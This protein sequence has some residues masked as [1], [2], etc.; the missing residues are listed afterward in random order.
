MPTQSPFWVSLTEAK[1]HVGLALWVTDAFK[2]AKVVLLCFGFPRLYIPVYSFKIFHFRFAKL[3]L[4]Y[5]LWFFTWSSESLSEIMWRISLTNQRVSLLFHK[6]YRCYSISNRHKF[7][8]EKQR[9]LI[10]QITIKNI[11]PDSFS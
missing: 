7:T 1:V 11:I 4:V 2:F 10:N 8:F 9:C 3:N 6:Y 5:I